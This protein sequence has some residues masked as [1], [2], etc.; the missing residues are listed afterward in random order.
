[1]TN[2]EDDDSYLPIFLSDTTIDPKWLEAVTDLE[3]I[4]E[5][6]VQDISNATRKGATVR[7]G[8]TLKL[9]ISFVDSEK[10]RMS[11]AIKQI[12]DAAGRAQS[13]RLGLAREALFYNKLAPD[14][15]YER[16]LQARSHG[17]PW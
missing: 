15:K 10:H 16:R 12:P 9:T 1:M 7:F 3:G 6:H 5:C 11:L 17:R 13:R 2:T 14:W 8:A 4:A